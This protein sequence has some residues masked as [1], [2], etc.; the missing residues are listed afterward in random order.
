MPANEMP[1]DIRAQIQYPIQ[2]MHTQFDDLYI[3]YQ[4]RDTMTFFNMEDMWD[5][6]D[7]VLGPILDSGLAIRFS[8]EPFYVVVDTADGLL[9]PATPRN[10]FALSMVFTSQDALN[11]R[12]IPMVYQDGDDYGRI[13]SL[14]VPK[15]H[16]FLGPEQADSAIDQNPE[17]ARQIAW[18]NRRGLEVIHG[19]TTTLVVDGEVI[20]VE[21][22][23][24]RSQQNPVTQLKAVAVVFRGVARMAPTLEEALRQAVDAHREKGASPRHTDVPGVE[25]TDSNV[26]EAS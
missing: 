15:G 13:V 14:Q 2:L 24:L 3:I 12:A 22:I 4:M 23:F 9:P 26:S 19:H 8:I 18:W 17:I 1:A 16:Y 10:Q 25:A 5:D 11:L 20:Y 21:P 7:E 6:G